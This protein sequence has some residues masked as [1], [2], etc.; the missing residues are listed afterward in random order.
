M[1]NRGYSSEW[2]ERIV[3][4]LV[5]YFGVSGS[6]RGEIIGLLVS[7]VGH[8]RIAPGGIFTRQSILEP[9]DPDY[10]R[11]YWLACHFYPFGWE[12]CYGDERKNQSAHYASGVRAVQE[13]YAGW[14]AAY[15]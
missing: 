5:K 14:C 6:L 7:G 1:S 8:F 12:V 10:A 9:G 11:R 3:D 13:L 15:R 4:L 2:A